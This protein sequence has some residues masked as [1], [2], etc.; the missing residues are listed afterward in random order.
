MLD[1]FKI[2]TLVPF[3]M[4]VGIQ[5]TRS[6]FDKEQK[7]FF[8]KLEDRIIESQKKHLFSKTEK[9]IKSQSDLIK[10]QNEKIV[11]LNKLVE[12]HTKAGDHLQVP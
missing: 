12:D 4:D 6:G 9:I 5:C 1:Y 11:K 8:N 10:S 3:T 7:S 2:L